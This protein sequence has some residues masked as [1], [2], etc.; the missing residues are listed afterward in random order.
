MIIS[1]VLIIIVNWNGLADTL[2]CLASLKKLNYSDYEVAVIDN[3]S[4]NNEAEEIKQKYPSIH[5]IK[6][7]TNLG[8]AGGNNL[9][10]EYGLKNDFDYFLLL[11]NDTIVSP[12]F[13]R[14]LVDFAQEKPE[15]GVAGSKILYHQ[16]DKIWFNG[17]KLRLF[18]GSFIHLEKSLDNQQS[19]IK[20]P[21]R[22]DY[23]SGACLLIKKEVVEKIG[24]LYEP[25][26]FC[27]EETDWCFRAQRAGYESWV[28]PQSVIWHKVGAS[29]GQQGDR[30]G[31]TQAYYY[32][33]NARLFAQRNF[34]GF[35]RFIF[36]LTHYSLASLY[37]L[38]YCQNH[39]ARLNYLKGLQ[40][41]FNFLKQ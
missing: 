25:Y 34:F 19:K 16:T 27:Y 3:D 29:T 8:F 11:N 1:K 40:D 13:L 14:I 31:S 5:L 4:K 24:L 38:L 7:K 9:G 10:L 6:S 33:R 12:D 17:G 2:E 37:H 41:S 20:Q 22:V 36:L 23:V 26:F 30:L 21:H 15:I 39:Q 18:L 28:V 35:K 32:A